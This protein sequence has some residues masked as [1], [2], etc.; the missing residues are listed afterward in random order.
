MGYLRE[1]MKADLKIAGYSPSTQRI[2]LHYAEKYVDHFRCPPTDMGANEIR[3][4]LL[5]LVEKKKASHNTV[6]HVRGALRF[7]YTVTLNR[8]VEVAWVPSPRRAKRLPEVLSGTEVAAILD[9][10]EQVKY[11]MVL[12]AM[13]GAGLRIS[14]ACKLYPSDIDSKRMF[15]RVRGKGN[16]ERITLLSRR[17]LNELREYWRH[18]RPTGVWLFPGRSKGRHVCDGTIRRVFGLAVDSV[19]ITK[20]VSPHSL[21]HTFATHLIDT[22]VDVTM[23]QA[24]LGHSSIRTTS[25]YT[26]TTIERI[27]R[28]TSPLDLLGSS[29]ADIFG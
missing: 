21:R 10:V 11:R 20:R 29:K 12:T 6:R 13:Y 3:Q 24:L 27:S 14:E 4:F 5:Y 28:T 2:Y 26:H 8:P 17:L 1:C 23:V 25:L 7:L 16:K 22:G 15:I 9:A 19:G 18:S